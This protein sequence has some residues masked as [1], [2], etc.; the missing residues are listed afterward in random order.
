[1]GGTAAAADPSGIDTQPNGVIATGQGFGIKATGAGTAVF[2]N[3]MR[4]TSGN[5]TLRNPL[6]KDR[7]WLKIQSTAYPL[8]SN[9]LIGFSEIT[10]EGID[11]GYDSNRLATVL[12]IYSG[13]E[14]EQVEL[15]IQSRELFEES[16]M[17]PIGFSSLLNEV[18]SY[19]ISL[20][21]IDSDLLSNTTIYL[22]DRYLNELTLLTDEAYGFESGPGNFPDRFQLLFEPESVLGTSSASFS[23]IKVFPNPTQKNIFLTGITGEAQLHLLDPL[24]R[25]VLESQTRD[26][27]NVREITLPDLPSGLYTL[28]IETDTTKQ[29]KKIMIR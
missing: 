3:S 10:T 19:K 15:G 23:E 20:S 6:N 17:I 13:I 7:I 22:F 12:S 24:G 28:L 18:T 11:A 2:N 8:Q 26:T 9:C 29:V 4:L 27:G 25:K 16:I 1:M 5:T 21:N 14:G